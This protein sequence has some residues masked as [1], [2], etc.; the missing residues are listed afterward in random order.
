MSTNGDGGVNQLRIMRENCERRVKRVQNEAH[1]TMKE[2]E[3]TVKTNKILRGKDVKI[4]SFSN[5]KYAA[6]RWRQLSGLPCGELL[7]QH[8]PFPLVALWGLCAW[9]KP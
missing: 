8:S 5:R 9:C 1:L 7:P 3:R 6:H 4:L 2:S